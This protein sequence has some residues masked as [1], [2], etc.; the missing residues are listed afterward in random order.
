MTEGFKTDGGKR[1]MWETETTEQ[2][3]ITVTKDE[4]FGD[5]NTHTQKRAC[6]T[7]CEF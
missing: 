3:R 7:C 5:I 6:L 2:L 4:S 1:G